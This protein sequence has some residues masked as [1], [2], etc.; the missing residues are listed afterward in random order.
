M[1]CA[2]QDYRR[3]RTVRRNRRLGRAVIV[4]FRTW[5]CRGLLGRPGRLILKKLLRHNARSPWYRSER[6]LKD[7]EACFAQQPL[8]RDSEHRTLLALARGKIALHENDVDKALNLISQAAQDQQWFGKIGTNENDVKF[9][10]NVS[11]AQAYRAKAAALKDEVQQ[12]A[13]DGGETGGR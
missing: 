11:L 9:A 2:R 4:Y 7:F 10:A 12:R 1:Q 6:A 5:R 3:S 8:R 13:L